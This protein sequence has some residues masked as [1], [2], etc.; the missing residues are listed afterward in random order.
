MMIISDID[1]RQLDDGV[2]GSRHHGSRSGLKSFFLNQFFVSLDISSRHECFNF[3][4][5][6][7]LTGTKK[8]LN[9]LYLTNCIGLYDRYQK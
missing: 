1:Q 6:S 2:L 7:I 3:L 8:M 9:F 5:R 4:C